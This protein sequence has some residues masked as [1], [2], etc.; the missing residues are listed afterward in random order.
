MAGDHI[1][2]FRGVLLH[3]HTLQAHNLSYT[4]NDP[5]LA[6]HF[7]S[8]PEGGKHITALLL[9]HPMSPSKSASVLDNIAASERSNVGAMEFEADVDEITSLQNIAQGCRSRL[10]TL[11][12][13]ED[14]RN[15]DLVAKEGHWAMRQYAEFNLWCTKVGV[16]GQGL[17]SIDVRLKDLPERCRFIRSLLSSLASDLK[18]QS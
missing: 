9:T 15:D 16:D 3:A 14:S 7:F 18:G 5:S 11:L 13:H 2:L 1:G 6:Y 12:Q 8:F 10:K 4:S 17:R